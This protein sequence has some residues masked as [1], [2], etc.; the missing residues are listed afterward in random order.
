VLGTHPAPLDAGRGR[1]IHR[2]RAPLRRQFQEPGAAVPRGPR[3]DLVAGQ[4]AQILQE[5]GQFLTGPRAVALGGVLGLG[6]DGGDR[7][8]PQE[9]G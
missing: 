3:R 1:Q 2:R 4:I 6:L 8:R 5:P 9:I 7:L